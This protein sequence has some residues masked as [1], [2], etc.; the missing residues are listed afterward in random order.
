MATLY[1][2]WDI[3][4]WYIGR[5]LGLLGVPLIQFLFFMYDKELQKLAFRP[6]IISVFIAIKKAPN[7]TYWGS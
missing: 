6:I 4:I 3:F 1:N 5:T 7:L 2:A